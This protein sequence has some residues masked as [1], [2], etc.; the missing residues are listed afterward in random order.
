MR[1][2]EPADW[3]LLVGSGSGEV[4]HAGNGGSSVVAHLVPGTVV[5]EIA[6]LRGA[7]RTATV[8]ATEQIQP[9][10]RRYRC[11]CAMVRSSTCGPSCPGTVSAWRG[12]PRAR[13]TAGLWEFRVN[14]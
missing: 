13:C 6:L 2:R 7:A 14:G 9:S 10:S 12:C 3:F 4:I 5:G 8:V 11:A 1:Q